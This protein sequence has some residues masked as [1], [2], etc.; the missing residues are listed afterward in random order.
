MGIQKA[1]KAVGKLPFQCPR[2]YKETSGRVT[3]SFK[4]HSLLCKEDGDKIIK[5][6]WRGRETWKKRVGVPEVIHSDRNQTFSW[7]TSKRVR[8]SFQEHLI[9]KKAKILY[10]FLIEIAI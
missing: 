9:C 2:K 8:K 7:R 1:G 5:R 4:I 10:T 6:G 3:S